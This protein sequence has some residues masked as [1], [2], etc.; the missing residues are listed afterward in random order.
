MNTLWIKIVAIQTLVW[1]TNVNTSANKRA[2]MGMDMGLLLFVI[3]HTMANDKYRGAPII[4]FRWDILIKRTNH[5]LHS[6]LLSYKIYYT[7]ERK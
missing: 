5:M 2:N 1:Y 3:Y 6:L 4:S 7:Q